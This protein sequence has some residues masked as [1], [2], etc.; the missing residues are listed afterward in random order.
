M[1]DG[2]LKLSELIKEG[3]YY[4]TGDTNFEQFISGFIY[5]CH[6]GHEDTYVRVEG[7]DVDLVSILQWVER[8]EEHFHKLTD[9][10][11]QVPLIQIM[12]AYAQQSGVSPEEM[13]PEQFETDEGVTIPGFPKHGSTGT[14]KNCGKNIRY[15]TYALDGV[16]KGKWVH[17]FAAPSFGGCEAVFGGPA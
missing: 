9:L 6:D 10:Q 4:I 14:C 12:T 8:H 2:L 17:T 3:R 5:G 1:S 7:L 16:D 11:D 13:F 15:I